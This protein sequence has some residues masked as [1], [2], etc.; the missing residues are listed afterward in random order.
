MRKIFLNVFLLWG[1]LVMFLGVGCQTI[2]TDAAKASNPEKLLP[3]NV[4]LLDIQNIYG[5]SIPQRP[6]Y[7]FWA[8]EINTSS[9][10]TILP[11]L[12]ISVEL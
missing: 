3:V 6:T 4:E 5:Y 7:D 11:S 12:G 8:N 2:R 10:I 1:V 9:D